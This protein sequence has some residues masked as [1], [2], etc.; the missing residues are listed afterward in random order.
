MTDKKEK[1]ERLSKTDVFQSLTD[2]QLAEIADV[3]EDKTV[4]AHT[5]LIRMGDPGDS[6]YIVHS[7][8]LRVFIRGEDKVQTTL[9]WLEPG[10]SFGEM[11]LLTDEPRST[12]IEAVEETHLFAL[13][14]KEFDVILNKNPDVYKN[15]IKYMSKLV[16]RDEL[17]I[18]KQKEREHKTTVLSFYDFVF[19]GIV[20]LLF[21]SIFNLSN[22]NSINVLPRLYDPDEIPKIGMVDAKKKFD[23]GQT[24]FIDARPRN[25]FDRDHIKGAVNLPLPSFEIN[26]MYISDEDVDKEIIVYGRSIGAQYDEGVARQLQLLGHGNVRILKGKHPFLPL[27]WTAL[28][29]WKEMGY[30]LGRTGNE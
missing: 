17:R 1:I 19:I 3:L 7:G 15:C 26:Y 28:D 22:P 4:P 29:T 9:N 13:G 25:F 11:A 21:A 24:I 30:P 8:K 27:R 14:K 6:F 5:L 2:E 20:I 18:L 12:N 10:D 23:E 16:K